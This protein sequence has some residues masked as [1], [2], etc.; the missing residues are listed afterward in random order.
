MISGKPLSLKQQLALI[1]AGNG[2]FVDPR[3]KQS[4]KFDHLR[5]EASDV[6]PTELDNAT[7]PWRHALQDALSLYVK[8]RLGNQ[9]KLIMQQNF[10][11]TPFKMPS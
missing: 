5:K 11:V 1:S 6:Q 3:S 7:E 10:G 2:R 4:F 9:L 8:V